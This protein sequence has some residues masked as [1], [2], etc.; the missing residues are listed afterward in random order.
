MAIKSATINRTKAAALKSK[1]YAF[2]L[3]SIAC[4]SI[5]TSLSSTVLEVLEARYVNNIKDVASMTFWVQSA[6][7]IDVIV[8]VNTGIKNGIFNSFLAF[9]F[10]WLVQSHAPNFQVELSFVQ[11]DC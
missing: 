4:F 8:D 7:I 3:S 5:K 6:V 1:T 2:F 9:Q 10:V 11:D